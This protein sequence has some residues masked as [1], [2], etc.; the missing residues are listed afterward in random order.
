MCLLDEVDC[1]GHF[2]NVILTQNPGSPLI[3]FIVTGIQRG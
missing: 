2:I 3:S 1:A